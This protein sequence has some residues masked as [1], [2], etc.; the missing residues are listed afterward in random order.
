MTGSTHMDIEVDID[1]DV[2]TLGPEISTNSEK[3]NV[4]ESNIYNNEVPP[5]IETAQLVSRNTLVVLFDVEIEGPEECNHQSNLK[6]RKRPRQ[7][8]DRTNCCEKIFREPPFLNLYGISNPV[9]RS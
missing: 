3:E 8:S 4:L 6:P 2:S 1:S 7:L 5:K 9:V